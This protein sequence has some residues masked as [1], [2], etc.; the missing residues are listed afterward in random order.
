VRLDQEENSRKEQAQIIETLSKQIEDSKNEVSVNFENFSKSSAEKSE[1]E[2]KAQSEKLE[3]KLQTLEEN[4]QKNLEEVK[5]QLE[6]SKKEMQAALSDAAQN[7]LSSTE[8]ENLR[9]E[10]YTENVGKFQSLQDELG[11]LRENSSEL[12][13]K[14]QSVVDD[15]AGSKSDM[16]AHIKNATNNLVNTEDL[17]KLRGEFSEENTEKFQALQGE[18]QQLRDEI[19]ADAQKNKEELLSSFSAETENNN[20]D[21]KKTREDISAI[22]NKLEEVDKEVRAPHSRKLEEVSTKTNGSSPA[23]ADRLTKTENDVTETL[24]RLDELKDQISILSNTSRKLETNVRETLKTEIN[25]MRDT[26]SN[27]DNLRVVEQVKHSVDA[28]WESMGVLSGRIVY[29][30][31]QIDVHR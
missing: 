12:S 13:S 21:I 8:L 25:R 31:A 10:I 1:A 7:A 19:Q 15:I 4:Y 2:A 3:E 27:M 17:E 9:Q 14:F 28:I 23:D 18:L 24:R 30:E 11:N 16:E 29:M 5:A 20:S 22:Y 6:T 26:I